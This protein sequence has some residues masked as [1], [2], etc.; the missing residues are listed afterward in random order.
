MA[1]PSKYSAYDNYGPQLLAYLVGEVT[2]KPFAHYVND[3][4]LHPLH[5][6]HTYLTAPAVPLTHRIAPF[7]PRAPA[8]IKPLPLMPDAPPQ[9]FGESV[10]TLRDMAILIGA[11][12]GPAPD[13]GVVTPRMR[14]LLF[15]IL[16]S[17]GP[18]GSA[19]GLVF[20]IV[21]TGARTLVVHGGVGPGIRC[22]LALDTDRGVGLFYCYGDVR[23]RLNADAAAVPPE[24]EE[25]TDAML[26]PLISCT[27]EPVV[28]CVRYPAPGWNDAWNGYLGLYVNAARHHHG[29][30][31][32]RTL[33]HPTTVTV[34]RVGDSLS[35][36][37]R[38]GFL[39]IAPGTFGHPDHLETF[40]F[41][42]NPA[43]RAITLSVSDRPSVYERPRLLD[44]PRV[45]PRVLRFSC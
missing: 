35:L 36:D 6:D 5:M 34:K 40:S 18:H 32:L 42:A 19:H 26:K 20:D 4:I 27:V 13:Q 43:T 21:R 45:L 39:E 3:S 28:P 23:P 17:N 8:L 7:Q 9:L 16:Q 44:D 15:S 1:N 10:A 41:I 25:V 2:G 30:S 24:F 38:T 31:R 37:G 33:V 11:L 14:S 29:F 12:L 22:M